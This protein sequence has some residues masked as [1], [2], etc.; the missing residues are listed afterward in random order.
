MQGL[1]LSDLVVQILNVFQPLDPVPHG[2]RV[3]VV[4]RLGVPGVHSGVAEDHLV[5]KLPEARDAT[6]G[7]AEV[8][9]VGKLERLP[10]A[11]LGLVVDPDA[12]AK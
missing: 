9:P 4:S 1:V 11:V 5:L 3:S 6:G 2:S 7:H 10:V 12:P 8:L